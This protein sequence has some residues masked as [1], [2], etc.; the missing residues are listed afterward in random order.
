MGAAY[1]GFGSASRL[2]TRS[3][4]SRQYGAGNGARTRDL[5][6]SQTFEVNRA[7]VIP[8]QVSYESDAPPTTP[9]RQ[10]SLRPNY[11]I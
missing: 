1:D 9:P 6:M 10:R 11:G 5:R 3:T 8:F 4:T 2:E 7:H